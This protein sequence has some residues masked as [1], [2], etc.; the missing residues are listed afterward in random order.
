MQEAIIQSETTQLDDLML[1]QYTQDSELET[2]EQALQQALLDQSFAE[3][4]A[5]LLAQSRK[6][7]HHPLHS[8]YNIRILATTA[9]PIQDIVYHNES[10]S[11]IP[12]VYYHDLG[13]PQSLEKMFELRC[14]ST[15]GT[16]WWRCS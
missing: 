13:K 3:A 15:V 6:G 1:K 14:T 12:H 2:T 10:L 7:D 16:V 9:Q 5:A 4:E 11:C 8:S